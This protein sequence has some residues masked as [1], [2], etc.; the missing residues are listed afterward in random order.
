ME[1]AGN[2]F[3]G[4]GLHVRI[5]A[6]VFVNHELAAFGGLLND[7]LLFTVEIRLGN[8]TTK[9]PAAEGDHLPGE[10]RGIRVCG[11]ALV[12]TCAVLV[13]GG[14]DP[15]LCKYDEVCE[16]VVIDVPDV[17]G[18]VRI[19]GVILQVKNVYQDEGVIV[20]TLVV[21]EQAVLA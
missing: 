15:V 14:C 7:D 2:R 8:Q 12:H 5:V 17:G 21:L 1:L 10:I 20:N 16:A 18:V 19:V 4:V 6:V 11:F 9:R 3:Q 13:D